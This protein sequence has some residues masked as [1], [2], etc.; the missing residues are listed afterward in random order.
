MGGLFSAYAWSKVWGF[1]MGF[2]TGLGNTLITSAAGILLALTLGL[3][4]G[5]M[6]T[7]RIKVLRAIARV[8]V[9]FIQNTPILLQM[10]FIYYALAFSGNSIGIVPT[11]IVALGIYHGAYMAEVFHAGIGSIPR[12]QFEAAQSQGFTYMESMR[13]VILPQTIK[14]ILP[15]MVNQ[16]VNLFKNT[17]REDRRSLH[18]GI[19]SLCRIVLPYVL[20]P[21]KAGDQLGDETEEER[22]GGCCGRSENCVICAVLKGGA[23]LVEKIQEREV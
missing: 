1:R 4:F 5:L 2:L 11:G 6:E 23:G 20:S 14:I 22:D 17:S 12:G 16:I 9:E 10:C 13:Y 19:S 3:V 15:P 21:F 18:T 7:G 8:Y